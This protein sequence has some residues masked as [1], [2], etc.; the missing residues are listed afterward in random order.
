MFKRLL[1]IFRYLINQVRA[2]VN[3]N[4]YARSLGVKLGENV[5]FY[6]V[7]PGMFSHRNPG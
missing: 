6:A 4:G 7:R 5:V 1:N 3:P 2:K